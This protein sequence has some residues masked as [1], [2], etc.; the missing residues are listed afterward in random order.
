MEE[1]FSTSINTTQEEISTSN[2]TIKTTRIQSTSSIESKTAP[3]KTSTTRKLR[4]NRALS[5]DRFRSSTSSLNTPTTE[6]TPSPTVQSHLPSYAAHTSSSMNKLR[7]G[8]S[9]PAQPLSTSILA[10]STTSLPLNTQT[11]RAPSTI[12]SENRPKNMTKSRSTQNLILPAST[13]PTQQLK[14]STSTTALRRVKISRISRRPPNLPP[15]PIIQSCSSSASSNNSSPTKTSQTKESD[16][17][18]QY[19]HHHPTSLPLRQLDNTNTTEDLMPKWAQ[20]CFYRTVV[21]G[22]KPLLLEDIPS[23][24]NKPTKRTSSTCSIESSDSLET[25]NELQACTLNDT[26]TTP[27]DSNVRRSLTV[28]DYRQIKQE[29][30]GILSSTIS[31]LAIGDTKEEDDRISIVNHLVGDVHKRLTD[32]ENLYSTVSQSSDTRDIILKQ[33]IEQIFAD[34]HVRIANNQPQQHE[35]ENDE[36]TAATNTT[37]IVGAD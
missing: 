31:E 17:T 33:Y 36:C 20:D 2:R 30:G 7:D 22:L 29:H 26:K 37:V 14:S 9:I 13:V 18:Q 21:L 12:V 28:P 3:P 5:E 35:Q 27:K 4:V 11:R 10:S 1:T 34:L 15:A 24:P 6:P 32:L 25:A 23:S 8:S 16:Q 19:H